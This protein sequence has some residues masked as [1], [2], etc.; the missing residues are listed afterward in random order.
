[1]FVVCAMHI[2]EVIYMLQ[3]VYPLLGSGSIN[4][5]EQPKSST[6]DKHPFLG[7]GPVEARSGQQKT[8]CK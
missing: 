5:L 4:T 1:M 7:N 3:H 8:P 2:I 6:I